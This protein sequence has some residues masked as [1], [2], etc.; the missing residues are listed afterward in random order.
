MRP[1]GTRKQGIRLR[2]PG[3]EFGIAPDFQLTNTLAKFFQLNRSALEIAQEQI[4]DTLEAHRAH[5][6][7]E[8]AL[9]VD[10]LSYNFLVDVYGNDMLDDNALSIALADESA[11]SVRG[12][13]ANHPAGLHYMQERMRAV[14]RERLCQ[15]WYVLM[16][17]I[18]RRNHET[19]AEL[20]QHPSDF[21]PAYRS[22]ICYRPM[23]RLGFQDFLNE[24]GL[25]KDN[26]RKGFFTHGV[27]K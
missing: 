26:G 2:L 25:W 14:N 12:M 21:S 24:R 4:K 10:T 3:H 8:A 22:S 5:F 11:L 19:I 15:W 16:D 23:P 9:K 27:L 1:D 18:W 20:D 6:A 7:N 17:D 13:L